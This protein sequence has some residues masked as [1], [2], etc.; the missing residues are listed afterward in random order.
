LDGLD[1]Y[2]IVVEA[3]DHMYPSEVDT[4]SG[5]VTSLAAAVEAVQGRRPELLRISAATDTGYV[6][7]R[8][9]PAVLFGPGDISRAHTD[10]DLVALDEASDSA[11]ALARLMAG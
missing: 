8:G 11:R 2:E 6:N 1:P 4:S 3:G 10:D 9:I 7:R 5:V